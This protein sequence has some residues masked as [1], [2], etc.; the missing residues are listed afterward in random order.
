MATRAKAKKEVE[1]P[2]Y[3]ATAPQTIG[4]VLSDKLTVHHVMQPLPDDRFFKL[5]EDLEDADGV[6]EQMTLKSAVW[7]ELCSSVT[8]YKERDDWKKGV[9][10]SHK[11]IAVETLRSPDVEEIL[12]GQ[13]EVFDIEEPITV[14]LVA[15]FGDAKVRPT[16]SF[17]QESKADMESMLALGEGL[18]DP[19]ALASAAKESKARAIHRI[20]KRLMVSAEGYIGDPPASH[21]TV[22]TLGFFAHEFVSAKKFVA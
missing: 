16:I 17:K 8:G 1:A 3:D 6:A 9:P 21:L 11:A 22:A 14:K 7:D 10:D 18:P 12:S 19:N 2:K 20:G 5:I 4:I 15:I 13:S